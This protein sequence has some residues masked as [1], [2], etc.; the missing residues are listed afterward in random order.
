MLIALN[1][2]KFWVYW[3]IAVLLVKPTYLLAD[4]GITFTDIVKDKTSGGRICS[5]AITPS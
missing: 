3:L 1:I 5:P 2:K 4:G